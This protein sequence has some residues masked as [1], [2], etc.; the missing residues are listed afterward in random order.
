MR[1]TRVW[2]TG[3]PIAV[4]AAALALLGGCSDGT[5]GNNNGGNGGNAGVAGSGTGGD[6]GSAGRAGDPSHAVCDAGPGY[7]E[8]V[9]PRS[10]SSVKAR[11]VDT[12]GAPVAE[13]PVQVC[14][15]SLCY[16][17]HTEEDGAVIGCIVVLYCLGS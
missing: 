15:T 12:Q 2:A 4:I 14:G 3:A 13:V 10:I 5:D 7:A 1:R 6:S 9:D 8:V 11:I 16:R 17:G